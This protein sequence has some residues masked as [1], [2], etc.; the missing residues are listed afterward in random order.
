MLREGKG[1]E[2]W[3]EKM[4]EGGKEKERGRGDRERKGRETHKERVNVCPCAFVRVCE[5][6]N[7]CELGAAAP[8]R[9]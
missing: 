1:R 5:R 7:V 3:G 4:R 8:S 6:V 9:S 2:R